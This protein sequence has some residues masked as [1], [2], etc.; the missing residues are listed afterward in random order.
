MSRAAHEQDLLHPQQAGNIYVHL[1]PELDLLFVCTCVTLRT[2]TLS[3]VAFTACMHTC[4]V[5]FC[6]Y[7]PRPC[8][9]PSKMSTPTMQPIPSRQSPAPTKWTALYLTKRKNQESSRTTGMPKQSKS[10]GE[11]QRHTEQTYTHMMFWD[12]GRTA[13]KNQFRHKKNI[14]TGHRIHPAITLHRCV[15]RYISCVQ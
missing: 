7:T 15:A 5:W 1:H 9:R 4:T 2:T 3:T 12:C 8:S 13:G 14:Q 10:W 11:G 6:G